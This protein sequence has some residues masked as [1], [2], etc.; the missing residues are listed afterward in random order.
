M[1]KMKL[2]R[3]GPK[4]KL[5]EAGDS[6]GIGDG[7]TFATRSRTGD[8]NADPDYLEFAVVPARPRMVRDSQ[9]EVDRAQPRCMESARD[10]PAR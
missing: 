3:S 7:P 6:V 4:R 8:L 9:F 5:S 2:W 10:L 1:E